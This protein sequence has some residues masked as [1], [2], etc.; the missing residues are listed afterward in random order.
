MDTETAARRW[1]DVWS[2]AWPVKDV[3]AIAALYSDDAVYRSHAFGRTY[4][5]P[6]GAREYTESAFANEE[7]LTC[8]FGD[9][10][11]SGG[12]AAVEWWAVLRSN[13]TD[14]TIAGTT[15]LRFASDG[16]VDEHCDYWYLEDSRR[17]PWPGW[18]K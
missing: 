8:W 7:A 2:R 1:A 3:D 14:Q 10:I 16:R 11:V 17:T 12:R 15:I 18:G 5:G 13:G 4:H 9:P 6:A